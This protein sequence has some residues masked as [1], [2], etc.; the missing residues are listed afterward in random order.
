MAGKLQN[1]EKWLNDCR[2]LDL[3]L[4]VILIHD[5][6][7]DA[8]EIEVSGISEDF[9][10]C[11][12]ITGIYGSAGLARNA[13]LETGKGD[14]VLFADSDDFVNVQSVFE[15]I[16]TKQL[17][18]KVICASYSTISGSNSRTNYFDV[19]DQSIES[20]TIKPGIWR[21][22]IDKSLLHNYKFHD[23][24]MAE[25]QIFLLENEIFSK[26][27]EFSEINLYNYYIGNPLQ[28]TAN[29]DRI[30]DLFRSIRYLK[31]R[32]QDMSDT[33]FRMAKIMMLSQNLTLIKRGTSRGK[34]KGI[35]LILLNSPIYLN[36]FIS[37]LKNRQPL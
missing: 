2:D 5:F 10:F 16:S 11:R 24:A 6:K 7:D 9:T 13:G 32:L 12:K 33:Q 4:E 31:T 29:S 3:D 14:W 1:L 15:L 37:Y 19:R 26:I 34:I 22:L 18:S 21:F 30:D 25:D 36:V 28:A 20:L 8:T 35:A 27:D 17:T 23:F